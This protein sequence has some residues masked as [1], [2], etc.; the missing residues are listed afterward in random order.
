[1]SEAKEQGFVSEQMSKAES[2]M[3][4]MHLYV[5]IWVT[6]NMPYTSIDHRMNIFF[7]L[8]NNLLRLSCVF[9]KKAQMKRHRKDVKT[10]ILPV[11][12]RGL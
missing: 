9:R 3:L 8:L 7:F 1:M 5:F 2:R 6:P 10:T 4:I 11:V 12:L